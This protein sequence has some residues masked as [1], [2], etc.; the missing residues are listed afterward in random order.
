M[1]RARV[2]LPDVTD[3]RAVEV[4]FECAA[5][6][7]VSPRRDGHPETQLAASRLSQ[8]VHF[9]HAF[10]WKI[11][12]RKARFI[13]ERA[14]QTILHENTVGNFDQRLAAQVYDTGPM[15]LP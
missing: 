3:E 5:N 13:F 8:K 1:S 15:F 11:N 2:S 12:V 7:G 9:L 14:L 10:R 6:G 4:A